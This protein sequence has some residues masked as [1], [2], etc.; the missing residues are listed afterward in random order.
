MKQAHSVLR[1]SR[2]V[3][4]K[5][6]LHSVGD[7]FETRR[8][9]P[10]ISHMIRSIIRATSALVMLAAAAN[11]QR[12]VPRLELSERIRLDAAAEDFSALTMNRQGNA[13]FYVG[14]RHEIV[15]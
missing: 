12:T 7:G 15:L 6:L 9:T 8:A 4:M 1:L 11:A 10:A 13:P 5:L 3:R 2:I 14:P